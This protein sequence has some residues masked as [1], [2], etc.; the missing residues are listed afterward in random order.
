MCTAITD[1][2]NGKFFSRT[3]DF[4]RSYNEKATVTPRSYKFDFETNTGF[5]LVGIASLIDGVPLY[6]DALNEAGL[7]AAAL[8]FPKSCVYNAE[9]ED[10]ENIPSYELIARV[11]RRCDGLDS[12]RRFLGKVNITGKSFKEGLPASPLHW[13]FADSQGCICVE[14]TV[15]GLDIYG[16]PFGVLTNEPPFP[17]HSAYVTNFLSLSASPPKNT[18]FPEFPLEAYSRGL[19]TFG[20]PGDFSS[21]SRFVRALFVKNHTEKYENESE[22]SKVNRFFR[23]TDTVSIPYGCV[24]TDR[25]ENV[26]TMYTSVADADSMTYYYTTF[27]DRSIRKIYAKDCD[28]DSDVLIELPI[29]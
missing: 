3:F 1:I 11:L 27:K 21:S 15:S 16:D 7:W 25:G 14:Q 10:K 12:A 26:C 17:Y 13:I 2:K 6:Y 9:K 5:A 23:M 22:E 4:E 28:L 20:L 8:N 19:G 29:F 24:K 18:L